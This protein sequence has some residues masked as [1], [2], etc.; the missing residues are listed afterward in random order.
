MTPANSDREAIK[1]NEIRDIDR[2]RREAGAFT[3]SASHE[4]LSA[5][6]GSDGGI[7]V[8]RGRAFHPSRARLNEKQSV[9]I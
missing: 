4:S 9:E 2:V 1:T 6:T 7:G 5:R 8:G 3:A